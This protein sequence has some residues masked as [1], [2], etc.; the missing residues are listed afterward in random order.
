M[1]RNLNQVVELVA[2]LWCMANFFGKKVKITVYVIFFLLLNLMIF[3]G[4]NQGVFGKYVVLL[5]YFNLYLYG[6]LQ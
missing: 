2:I 6:M 5:T 4:I 3:E 1:I